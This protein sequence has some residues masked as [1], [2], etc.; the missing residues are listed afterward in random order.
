MS[1]AVG[2]TSL[3]IVAQ[4]WDRCDGACP[5]RPIVLGV[6]LPSAGSISGS[7]MAAT[8]ACGFSG[9]AASRL[10]LRLRTVV[11]IEPINLSTTRGN[12]RGR[13]QGG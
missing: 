9:R 3:E 11:T 4:H 7:C 10:S 2:C 5:V 1:A 13:F 8:W 6:W 12:T